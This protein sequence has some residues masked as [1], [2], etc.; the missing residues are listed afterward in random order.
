M[1]SRRIVR[2]LGIAVK[3]RSGIFHSRHCERSE[4]TQELR[5]FLGCFGA[6][7]LAMTVFHNHQSAGLSLAGEAATDFSKRP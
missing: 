2:G 4:A 1:F 3:A 5:Y 6:A 7:R